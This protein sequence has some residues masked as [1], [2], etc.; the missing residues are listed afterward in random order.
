MNESTIDMMNL[1]RRLE[2]LAF[3]IFAYQRAKEIDHQSLMEFNL[4]AIKTLCID[5]YYKLEAEARRE[6]EV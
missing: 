4:Y 1:D 5:I 3:Q 6:A 2:T